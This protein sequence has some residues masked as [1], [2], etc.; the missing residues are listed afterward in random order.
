[1]ILYA[2]P[3]LFWSTD[4]TGCQFLHT[5]P[6]SVVI[7]DIW[8]HQKT[9]LDECDT[10][11]VR[12]IW[13]F[14]STVYSVTYRNIYFVWLFLV[15]RNATHSNKHLLNI[16]V[17]MHPYV[18]IT[19]THFLTWWKNIFSLYVNGWV[20]QGFSTQS[21]NMHQVLLEWRERENS[22]CKRQVKP[23]WDSMLNMEKQFRTTK[24]FFFFVVFISFSFNLQ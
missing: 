21:L 18:P 1:M 16:H 9:I 8:T 6:L 15:P 4:L 7:N 5:A 17:D 23:L 13:G 19:P 22:K 11:A 3:Y 10:K 12:D 24:I 2:A 20:L 14:H